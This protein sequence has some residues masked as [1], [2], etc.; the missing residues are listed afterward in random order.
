MKRL[1]SLFA[2]ALTLTATTSAWALMD[3]G[4]G[5]HTEAWFLNGTTF[6]EM[7]TEAADAA[8]A[9]KGL[10]LVW[11][12]QGCGSCKK[13]HEVNFQDAK[14]TNYL[15]ANFNMMSIAVTLA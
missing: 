2:F 10:I 9:D 7:Q 14:L 1:F 8:D 13:L 15:K 6:Y 4:D 3:R 5:I 11:E 12:Q